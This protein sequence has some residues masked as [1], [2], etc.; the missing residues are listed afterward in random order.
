MNIKRLIKEVSWAIWLI[1]MYV[2]FFGFIIPSLLNIQDN[3]MVALGAFI[4][5]FT[6]ASIPVVG[7]KVYKYYKT[8]YFSKGE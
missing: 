7:F 8:T 5:L 3:V 4:M 2:S 6:V 1:I